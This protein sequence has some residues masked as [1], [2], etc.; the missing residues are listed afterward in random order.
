[1]N[2]KFRWFIL[3]Y[4]NVMVRYAASLDAASRHVAF[5][6][7]LRYMI[8]WYFSTTCFKIILMDDKTVLSR[9]LRFVLLCYGLHNAGLVAFILLCV[10]CFAVFCC[11][12]SLCF[13]YCSF[14]TLTLTRLIFIIRVHPHCVR[15]E[16]WLLGQ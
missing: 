4:I 12:V 15:E 6:C 5:S 14:T 11:L 7:Y 10:V 16:Q 2:R 9:N 13:V 1:M 8:R 3:R